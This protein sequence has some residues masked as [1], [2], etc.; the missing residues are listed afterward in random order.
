MHSVLR[1]VVIL[2]I[3]IVLIRSAG[4]MGGGK[5]FGKGDKRYALFLLIAVDVQLLVGLALYFMGA[6]GIKNIQN[7]GMSGVMADGTSR[8]FAVEHGLCMLLGLIL[9]HIG[10][11]ATKKAIP[12]V[13][14]FKRLFW[15]TLIAAVI[16]LASV[17]WPF[18]S[19]VARPWFPGM[20]VQQ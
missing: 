11:S 1:W 6:W 3:V 12:D 17:P 14:K 18:R 10:Y 8:F 4:G 19:D 13:S 15:Y 7:Q 16:M 20:S 2:L 5:L 9:I